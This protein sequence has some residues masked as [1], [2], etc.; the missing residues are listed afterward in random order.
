MLA[1][2]TEKQ[3]AIY[4]LG[5]TGTTSFLESIKEKD[6]WHGVGELDAQFMNDLYNIPEQGVYGWTKGYV[7]QL[8]ALDML[9]NDRNYKPIFIVR[10][11]WQRYVSG[12]MEVLQDTFS[13]VMEHKDYL[14]M[15]NNLDTTTFTKQLDRLYYLSE[16]QKQSD[17][18]WDSDFPYPSDF[19]IH[20]NYHIRNWL[21][22]IE[23][24][25][26]YQIIDNQDLNF[27]MADL[28]LERQS[29]NVSDSVLKSK[30]EECLKN[31]GIYF[32]IEKYLESETQRY[33]KLIR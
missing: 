26:D 29:S 32:Y 1:I 30:F 14:Q 10:D 13:V 2:N 18:K 8:T 33:I 11:P 17:F 12:I 27:F 3:I 15:I 9:V 24:F 4:S 16:F 31:T 7:D 21:F 5:K 25:S 20:Y 23:T 6:Y 22:E 19:A 28:D